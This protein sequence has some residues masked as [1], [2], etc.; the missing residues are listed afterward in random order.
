MTVRVGNKQAIVEKIIRH[1]PA[2]EIF[3]ELFSGAGGILLNKPLA[4]KN[5]VN[6]N[7][8]QLYHL[9]SYLTGH[10]DLKKLLHYFEI[11]P[12]HA[13]LFELY[14]NPDYE[15]IHDEDKATR[16]L[17]LHNFGFLGKSET[18]KFGS[19]NPKE[20]LKKKLL[21]AE[22]FFRENS[23]K[24]QYSCKDWKKFLQSYSIR[25][26]AERNKI[27][28]YADPPYCET[29]H[30]YEAGGFDK[31]KTE[32]LLQYLVE[33][34]CTFFMSEFESDFIAA[35]SK[36]YKLRLIIVGERQN[37]KNRRTEVLLTNYIK[38]TV[39]FDP[40]KKIFVKDERG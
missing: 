35:L 11:I 29:D 17:V 31:A 23:N 7:D 32:E 19:E 10:R 34:R 12:Y 33:F 39:R 28:I 40:I 5:Y 9:I 30:N 6:D 16:F 36:K 26:D 21:Y 20:V 1:F 27:L 13:T 15:P 25:D 4:K 24:I 8:T 38:P 2:H 3:I 14:K 22:K 37:L 18:M